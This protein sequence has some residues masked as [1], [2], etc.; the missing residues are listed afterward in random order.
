MRRAIVATVATVVGL[1][2]LLDY[3]AQSPTGRSGL[4]VGGGPTPAAPSTST[5]GGT[6]PPVTTTPGGTASYTGVDVAYQYGDIQVRIALS[7]GRI[8]AISIPQESASDP[9]SQS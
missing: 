6:T 1:V 7:K 9:R 2:V 8:T 4:V 5:A 3:R